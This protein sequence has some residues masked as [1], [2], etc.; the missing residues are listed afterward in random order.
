MGQ[1]GSVTKG[2]R[3]ASPADRI[4]SLQ[5]QHAKLELELADENSRPMPNAATVKGIKHQKLAIK[6]EITKLG[7]L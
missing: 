6:D 2:D 4:S 7:G 5:E 3:D 1:E